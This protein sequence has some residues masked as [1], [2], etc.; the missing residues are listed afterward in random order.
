VP[1]HDNSRLIKALFVGLLAGLISTMLGVGGGLIM[2][3]LFALLGVMDV[4]RAAGT[5]LAIILP[6]IAVGIAAQ[7]LKEPGDVYWATAGLLAIGAITGAFVGKRLHRLLPE[8]PFRLAFCAVM[9]VVAARM[10][11]VIPETAPLVADYPDAGQLTHIA[12]LLGLGLIAGVVS[13]LF[14]LGGGVVAVPGLALAFALFHDQ[15]TATRAT[16]LA[17]ILP[18]SLVGAVL[19]WR[20]G[21]VDKS[22]AFKVTPVAAAGA[23]GG[24]FLAYAVPQEAL[25][26]IFAVMILLASFRLAMQKKRPKKTVEKGGA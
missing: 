24:V 8:T 9:L 21:N 3:P 20:A 1:E 10:L 13:A 11:N 26:I 19:H 4:K 12:Y 16:S 7:L 22:L 5:S 23:V 6:V 17:M 2:V 25:K 15:F 18:T 14:G